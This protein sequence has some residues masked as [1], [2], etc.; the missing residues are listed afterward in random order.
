MCTGKKVPERIRKGI[1]KAKLE[2][3]LTCREIAKEYRVGKSTVVKVWKHYK[4]KE[5]NYGSCKSNGSD[6]RA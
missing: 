6:Q 5:N 2:T 1:I 4:D 3:F